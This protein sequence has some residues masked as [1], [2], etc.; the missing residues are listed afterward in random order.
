MNRT[1]MVR[2]LENIINLQLIRYSNI[3][4]G[5]VPE[6]STFFLSQHQI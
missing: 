4:S 2:F 1:F 3:Q 6:I 5:N